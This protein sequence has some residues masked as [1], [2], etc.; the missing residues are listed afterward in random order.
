[1]SPARAVHVWV[2]ADTDD[3]HLAQLPAGIEVHRM[4]SDPG[5]DSTL[6]PGEFVVAGQDRRALGGALRRL[7]GLRV[8]QSLSA[9]VD[10]LIGLIPSGVTLADGA[11]I[12]DVAVAEW[13]VM[14]IL[15]VYRHL[16]EYVLNQQAE[17]WRRAAAGPGK[18]LDGATVMI[19]GYGS[20]GRAVEK[21]LSGFGTNF[22][23]VARR[24]RDGAET[25]DRLPALIPQ[26]D[27]IVV[28]LPLTEETRGFVDRSFLAK[29]RPGALLVNPSRGAVVDTA[30][31]IDALKEKRIRA[32]LDVTDPEPLPEGH[33]LWKQDGLLLTPHIAGDVEREGERAW[34]LVAQQ[35]RRYL[36]G[37]PLENV[38]TGGY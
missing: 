29:M 33:E 11:G 19:L 32:A 14:A 16:P 9:G 2:P 38:V 3:G 1:M 36:A 23:R 12:H 6:G 20:I 31:L 5:G 30:A 28:S 26:A 4:P 8:V 10:A 34:K 22:L 35:L 27:V 21:R 24:P 7:E 13:V 25:I 18:D 37:E 17:A 15:A